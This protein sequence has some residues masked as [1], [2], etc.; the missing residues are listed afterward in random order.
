MASFQIASHC[1]AVRAVQCSPGSAVQSGQCGAVQCCH[2]N[3]LA[4]S[5]RELQLNHIV[6][7]PAL[8][9]S[10]SSSGKVARYFLSSLIITESAMCISSTLV[11]D[12]RMNEHNFALDVPGMRS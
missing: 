1:T 9:A 10:T 12:F 6:I 8:N 4:S 5:S 3:K 2:T 11:S 7:M